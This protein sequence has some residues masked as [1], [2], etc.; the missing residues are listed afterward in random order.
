[1]TRNRPQN[2]SIADG[3]HHY[4]SNGCKFP[5]DDTFENRLDVGERDESDVASRR[6]ARLI[7]DSVQGNSNVHSLSAK[8]DKSLDLLRGITDYALADLQPASRRICL[9]LRMER[10]T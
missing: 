10:E 3:V 5:L 8:S 9:L 2:R 4:L 6:A 1:M 7:V